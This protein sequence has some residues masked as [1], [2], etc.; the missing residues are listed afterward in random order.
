M[1]KPHL[2]LFFLTFVVMRTVIFDCEQLRKPFTGFYTYCDNLARS[3]PQ[4]APGPEW[5]LGLYL[6]QPLVGTYDGIGLYKEWKHWHK[7][8]LPTPEKIS[9]WHCTH[10]FSKYRPTSRRIPLLTTLHDLNFLHMEMEAARRFRHMSCAQRVIARSQRIVT[11]S[12]F[13]REDILQHLDTRGKTVDVVYNGTTPFTGEI[14][15]PAQPPQRPFLLNINRIA[16]NKNIHVLPALIAES[17]LDLIIIGGRED[18]HYYQSI[19]QEAARWKVQDRIHFPGPMSEGTLHWYMQNCTAFA[20]PSL[21]EGFGLPVLEM[22]QYYKPIFSSDHSSLPEVGGDC[23]FYLDHDFE[24]RALQK[25]LEDGLSAF[26][27]GK[28]S[29][30]AMQERFLS[31]SWEKAA[32]NYWKIYQEML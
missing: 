1:T 11:I 22:M 17:D 24:P 2:L 3:L 9:L 29:R 18:E 31:F 14:I 21:C 26:A 23:V 25:N 6:P 13:A 8:F 4:A 28:I 20:F 15:A 5:Q 16:R 12:R 32:R 19:L 27:A 7:F 10:Q 30:E